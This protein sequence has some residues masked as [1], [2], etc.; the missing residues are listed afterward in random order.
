[1]VYEGLFRTASG[2]GLCCLRGTASLIKGS[3]ED[4]EQDLALCDQDL[5]LV[6]GG[7]FGMAFEDASC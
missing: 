2:R 5:G 1:M 3:R 4:Q 6:S 7:H